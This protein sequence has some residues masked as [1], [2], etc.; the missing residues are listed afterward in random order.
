MPSCFNHDS[1]NA[2]SPVNTFHN[3]TCFIHDRTNRV[4][5]KFQMTCYEIRF[6]LFY[7]AAILG[8]NVFFCD[9]KIAM[10]AHTKLGEF[11]RIL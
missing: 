2:L 10:Q 5:A 7:K 11:G 4:S 8:S 3:K 9:Y 6:I 1:H